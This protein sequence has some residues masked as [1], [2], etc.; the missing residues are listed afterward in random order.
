MNTR[1]S[2]I[3]INSDLGP[4]YGRAFSVGDRISIS[5]PSKM[6][7]MCWRRH[8]HENL[9]SFQFSC[10]RP[11]DYERHPGLN[12]GRPCDLRHGTVTQHSYVFSWLNMS[13]ASFCQILHVCSW[14]ST[15]NLRAT[16]KYP[17]LLIILEK[18]RYERRRHG[19]LEPLRWLL[20]TTYLLMSYTRR[21]RR[22]PR[23][24]RM[25]NG[26]IIMTIHY[27]T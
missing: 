16:P 9:L 11:G 23:I 19:A 8:P 15:L 21:V 7:V 27:K 5:W 25:T 17:N 4:E 10:P 18:Y 22:Y 14:I 2:L 26:N 24:F 20:R 12:N 13:S 1:I 3:A 6:L